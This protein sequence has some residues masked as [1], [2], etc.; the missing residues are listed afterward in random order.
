[1][2]FKSTSSALQNRFLEVTQD[3]QAGSLTDVNSLDDLWPVMRE[4]AERK[5]AEEPILGSYF[6]AT[7]LNHKSFGDA[8]SFRLASKLNN[9][10]LPTMLIRDVI[11]EAGT[12]TMT[13]SAQQ[14][15]TSSPTLPGTRPAETFPVRFCCS[16]AITRCKRI[17]LRTGC[18][19]RSG[20]PWRSFSKSDQRNLGVDIHPAA[21]IG[22]GIMFDH[23]TGIVIGETAVIEDDVSV[24]TP[25]PWA[26]PA[27]AVVTV[28]ENPQGNP[29]SAGC[30]SSA[31]SDW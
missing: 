15:S 6:H 12:P 23:A 27:K 14:R 2:S 11:A 18:G 5:A 31:T 7:I 8:L 25:L 22:S 24:C 13:S 20:T 26:A 29:L 3:Q 10:M 28:T 4:E 17:A 30:K 9:P 19:I 1:M 21:R 16:K